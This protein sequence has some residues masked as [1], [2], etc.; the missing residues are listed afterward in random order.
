MTDRINPP[1]YKTQEIE[2]IDAM[3]SAF[4]RDA[5]NIYCMLNAFKYIWRN[6]KKEGEKNAEG[7]KKAMWYLR[8]A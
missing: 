8:F 7:I 4:G 5:V 3:V 6:G 1:H 2:C